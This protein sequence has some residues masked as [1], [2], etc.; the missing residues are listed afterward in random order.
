M[1][2]TPAVSVILPTYNRARLL[3]RSLDSV[4]AQTYS[5]LEILVVDDGSEDDTEMLVKGIS[6]ARIR[7]VRLEMRSG[8]ARARNVG[9]G[10][11]RGRSIAFQDSDDE[12]LPAKLERQMY[13]FESQPDAAVVYSDMYRVLADGRMFYHRSP[14]IVRGC[15]INPETRYWQ[16]Y[17]LGMQCAVVRRECLER[18]GL[19]DQTLPAFED[20]EL[21]LRLAAH[22]DFVHLR[23][24]LVNYHETAGLSTDRRAELGARHR[25]V[26]KYLGVLLRTTPLFVVEETANALL[27]RSLLPIVER[28]FQ[29]VGD[30]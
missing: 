26:R 8:A 22:Y 13:T 17:M 27:R 14:T 11:A 7:Y 18:I 21:F 3:P 9:I 10:H 2:E 15:L 6:D 19:F 30:R 4:L 28:H 1:A 16:T 5:N 12:W 29:P 25:L 24:P 23:E 20:L